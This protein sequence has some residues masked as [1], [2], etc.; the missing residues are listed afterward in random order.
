MSDR[1]RKALRTLQSQADLVDKDE[2]FTD[3]IVQ[4]LEM[5][6]SVVSLT[7][8]VSNLYQS[9]TA[10]E[11]SRI[12]LGDVIHIH[13]ETQIPFDDPLRAETKSKV[14][15]WLS[16]DNFWGKQDNLFE[17]ALPSSGTWILEN[18][19]FKTWCES[20]N[21]LLWCSGAPGT[22]KTILSSIIIHH[23]KQMKSQTVA[24]T[25][26]FADYREHD[27]QSMETLFRSLLVQLF[28]QG[29][30]V[31]EIMMKGL[32]SNWQ[33]AKP[34]FADY[35]TWLQDEVRRREKV[36]V[37]IDA[38]DE[39]RSKE[40]GRRFLRELLE[41]SPN[42]R[43]LV[44]SR[45]LPDREVRSSMSEVEIHPQREDVV[46]YI[47]NRL[48]NSPQLRLHSRTRIGFS[49]TVMQKL[50]EANDRMYVLLVRLER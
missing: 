27:V 12:H 45:I 25:W 26:I 44:T 41:L 33:Q 14:M 9:I 38:L 18:S 29:K 35:R 5:A 8:G 37:V 19:L 48:E 21:R 42:I 4:C 13:N 39:L 31:S 30:G 2:L 16:S 6:Q 22:G 32:G 46:A 20:G 17:R 47:Q 10:T 43:I 28:H 11:Q 40:L 24:L 34:T 50:T 49:D 15:E 3:Q 36:L 1:F 23:L 7:M